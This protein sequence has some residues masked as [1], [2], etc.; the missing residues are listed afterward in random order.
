M[1]SF[2]SMM[3]G[4]VNL[5]IEK[6]KEGFMWITSDGY[7]EDSEGWQNIMKALKSL[8][9]EDDLEVQ[10]MMNAPQPHFRGLS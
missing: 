7:K 9:T 1:A 3:I 8:Q 10:N 6:D 2:K 5:Y 4:P